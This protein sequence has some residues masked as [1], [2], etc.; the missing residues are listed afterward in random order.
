M[1]GV[2]YGAPTVR[3]VLQ[4]TMANG[5]TQRVVTDATWTENAGP[6]SAPSHSA[7]SHSPP[8]LVRFLPQGTPCAVLTSEAYL[9]TSETS[10]PSSVA[11]LWFVLVL[12]SSP[13]VGNALFTPHGLG[14]FSEY[15]LVREL[16][17]RLH[18]IYV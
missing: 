6:S 9:T 8:S 4:L 1:N 18:D 16:D 12:H 14:L 10:F 13:A 17:I 7:P 11:P 15:K 5:Q 2:G 3:A